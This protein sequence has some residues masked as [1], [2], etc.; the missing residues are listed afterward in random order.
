MSGTATRLRT[1]LQLQHPLPQSQQS[2]NDAIN[3]YNTSEVS[4]EATASRSYHTRSTGGHRQSRTSSSQPAE[5]SMNEYHETTSTRS[6]SRKN[7]K[8]ATPGLPSALSPF[9][10]KHQPLTLPPDFTSPIRQDETE[11]FTAHNFNFYKFL[12][13]E[14]FGIGQPAQVEPTA[15]ANIMNFLNVP[16][17]L[18]ALLG[19]GFFICLDVFLY[20]FTY[21]P[22]RV[23]FALAML[24][25]EAISYATSLLTATPF[26]SRR[27]SD[28]KFRFHR[29]QAYDLMRCVLILVGAGALSMLN[30]SRLYHFIRGQSMIKLYVLT[31]IMDMLDSLLRSFGHDAFDSLFWQTRTHPEQVTQL[32]TILLVVSIYIVLHSCLYFAHTATLTVAINSSDKSLV[33][34]VLLNNVAELKAF[35]FKKFDNRLLF[36]LACAD[37]AERFKVTLFLCCNLLVAMT[38]VSDDSFIESH[39]SVF[40]LILVGEA[41]TDYIK[42]AFVVRLNH[43]DASIF[44]DFGKVLRKDVLN[45]HKD[46]IILDSS[47]ALTRRVGLSQVSHHNKLIVSIIF[48][49]LCTYFLVIDT[50]GVC[51]YPLCNPGAFKYLLPNLPA[52]FFDAR[53]DLVGSDGVLGIIGI[54]DSS[55]GRAD[56][57]R[58]VCSQSGIGGYQQGQ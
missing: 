55:W 54:Q 4:Q 2:P 35:V 21:L 18:E 19:F 5:P 33:T 34:L 49:R 47:Y 13:V 26:A 10:N 8:T 28:V 17:K 16:L 53:V 15:V 7:I 36:Q 23:L 25:Y 9:V 40:A 37:V 22:V 12:E 43:I 50:I 41:L 51:M 45:C 31:A 24:L 48:N 58:G 52:D 27:A 42:H 20:I 57:L 3:S 29:S 32:L 14:M 1:K 30:M 46:K 38:E 6:T 44:D 11:F 56:L 39:V